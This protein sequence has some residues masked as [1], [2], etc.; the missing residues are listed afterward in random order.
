MH[1]L[2]GCVRLRA[3]IGGV[4]VL[5]CGS[6]YLRG[7]RQGHRDDGAPFLLRTPGPATR[8]VRT[9]GTRVRG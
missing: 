4:V 1:A 7:S 8:T 5:R 6:E 3:I 9:P 2:V